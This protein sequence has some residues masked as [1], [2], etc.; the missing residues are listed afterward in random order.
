M[1]KKR[2]VT[3]LKSKFLAQATRWMAMPFIT[4]VN[5]G[6][7]VPGGEN[8]KFGAPP[9]MQRCPWRAEDVGRSSRASLG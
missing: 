7:G 4:I 9:D 3:R 5:T 6:E 8:N 1:I 2:K